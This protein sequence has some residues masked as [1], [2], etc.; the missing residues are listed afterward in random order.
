VTAEERHIVAETELKDVANGVLCLA[1]GEASY[2]TGHMLVLDGGQ[3]LGIV[4]DL[5]N[6]WAADKRAASDQPRVAGGS[7]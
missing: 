2:I 1:S 3:T 7:A 6:V 5:E 4:A